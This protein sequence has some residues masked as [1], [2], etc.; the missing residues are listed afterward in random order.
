MCMYSNVSHN[1][2]VAVKLGLGTRL[3]EWGNAGEEI[4]ACFTG[5]P[6]F[7]DVPVKTETMYIC[8]KYIPSIYTF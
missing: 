8:K 2:F 3:N 5:L 4:N 6:T 1:V 7:S